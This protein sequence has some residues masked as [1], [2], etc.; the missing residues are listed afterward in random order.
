MGYR[1]IAPIRNGTRGEFA[2]VLAVPQ[3]L[4]E[5]PVPG[6]SVAVAGN[7]GRWWMLLAALGM[8]ICAAIGVATYVSA[9]AHPAGLT[10]T[11]LTDFTDSATTPALSPDGHILAFIRADS[12][13]MSAGEIYVK[14]LPDGEAR[15]LTHD[16]RV[17]YDLA[18]SPDGSQIAYTVLEGSE[19][20]T[21]T[22]SVLGGDSQLL[23]RNAAGLT[24]LD[25]QHYLFS[26]FRSGLHLGVVTEAVTGENFREV[27][28]PSHE[29]AMAHY[30][31][32][33]PDRKTALVVEMNG[34]GEW[35]LCRLISLD[36]AFS[37]KTVGPN[38][39]CT[40]AGW[41]PLMGRGCTLLRR[42][43]GRVTYGGRDF[44][45]GGRSR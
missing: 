6:R 13:F 3:R 7:R 29:R 4:E 21:Y 1:F 27:Y 41:S 37:A 23:L 5:G 31:F 11:Q 18:F 39:A 12:S 28:Y 45:M 40:S 38:G 33:S 9:R 10:Y 17:K 36:G 42:W 2:E 24:W 15:P 43:T 30:S 44:R 8:V 19:F 16:A 22:V 26:R 25:P 14:M 35:T 34:Q 32:A 20:S